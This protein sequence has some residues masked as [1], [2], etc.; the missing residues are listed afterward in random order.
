MNHSMIVRTYVGGIFLFVVVA[1]LVLVF[2]VIAP[3][4]TAYASIFDVDTNADNPALV[5]CTAAPDDCS[6]RGAITKA[7]TNP[8]HDSIT[9]ADATN[10]IPI[11]LAGAVSE[12]YNASGDLD[13]LEGDDLT[14]QGNGASNT[15]IDGDGVDRV[16][17][18]CPGGGCTITVVFSGITIRNGG[19]VVHGGGIFNAG[20]TTTVDGCTIG[21]NSATY[22][23]GISNLAT[24]NVQ[25]RSIIGGNG[26][27]NAVTWGGG[28]IY[29]QSGTTTVKNS[30]VIYNTADQS[31][32]GI[33]NWDGTTTVDGSMVYSNTSPVGG[34]IYNRATLY[35]QNGSAIGAAG[36]GNEATQYGGGIYNYNGVATVDGSTVSANT[37]SDGGGI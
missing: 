20:G 11:V 1:L 2:T 21:S 27:S 34:G 25:N 37:A 15:I 31:G 8:G 6:L 12:D 28:G 10:G 22:G 3:P 17:H 14:I 18:V 24:L 19:A 32:G 9:F 13:V 7:N 16:F 33:Y 4:P 26:M 29:N 23:G 35:V 30:T 5:A 36:V